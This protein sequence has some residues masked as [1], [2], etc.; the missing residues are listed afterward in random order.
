MTMSS[1]ARQPFFLPAGLVLAMAASAGAAW[2]AAPDGLAGPGPK[3]RRVVSLD[4]AGWLLA[5]DPKNVGRREQ[6]YRTARAGAKATRVPWIIQDPFPGYHGVA[7]YWRTFK[8]GENPHAGGRWLLRFWAVD[9][10]A[11]V[12]LNGTRVGGHEGGETP[13]VLDVTDALRPAAANLL[14]VR[15]L[16]PTHTPIDGIVLNQTPHRNKVMPYRSGSAW[17]QGGIVDSVELL[18]VPAVRVDD[19][20]VRAEPKTGLVRVRAAVRN[21]GTAPADSS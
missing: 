1:D 11:D 7:W 19:L 8:A 21:A 6:W 17:N 20:F 13:F 15:V 18:A 3:T 4:G 10:K 9:Y 12:W 16:N 14:A 5:P 2:G